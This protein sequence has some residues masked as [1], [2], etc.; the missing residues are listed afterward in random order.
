[1]SEGTVRGRLGRARERLRRR[2]TSRG[3]SVPAALIAAGVTS[4]AQAAIPAPLVHSTIRIALGF[5]AGNTAA[6]LAQGV[7]KSILWNQL[8]KVTVLVLLGIGGTY[9]LW[10]ALASSID[11]KGQAKSSQVAAKAGGEPAVAPARPVT[12]AASSSYRMTGMVRVE[13]TGEAVKGARLLVRQGEIGE[14]PPP[15]E[16]VV[17]TGADGRFAIDLQAGNVR[18]WFNAAPPGY[19]I[20]T[21]QAIFEAFAVGPNEPLIQKEYRVRKGTPW[22]VRFTRGADHRPFPGYMGG[23]GTGGIFYAQADDRGQA[24][25]TLPTEGGKVTLSILE[26][27]PV[28]N[29]VRTGSLSANLEWEP[30][31]RPDQLK[32]ITRLEGNDRRFRLIDI[33]AKSATLQAHSS[34]EPVK[35]DGKLIIRVDLADRSSKDLGS[36]TG[37]VLDAQGQPIE[38]AEVAVASMGNPNSNEPRHRATTD[39][40][41]RYRLL[42][43]PR[44]TIDGRP[45]P[46]RVLVSRSGYAGLATRISLNES[47]PEKPQIA[48]PIRLERGVAI[49][50]IV[51]DHR[52]QPVA[53]ASVQSNQPMVRPGIGGTNQSVQT[54]DNGRFI[55]RDLH[56]GILGLA[57]FHGKISK[58]FF[59]LAD[60]SPEDVRLQLPERQPQPGPDL[61]ALRAPAPKPLAVGQ[62][63]PD[64]QVGPWSDGRERE[65]SEERGKVVVLYFWGMLFW[66][67]VSALPPMEKLAFEFKPREVDFLAIHNAEPDPDH[68]QTQAR[69]VLAFKGASMVNAIDQIRILNHTRGL[70]AQQYGVNNYPVVIVIDRAGKIAFRSDTAEG[71]RNPVTVFRQIVAN[72]GTMTEEKAIEVIHKALA[73]EIERVLK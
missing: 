60:G 47:D 63:A 33:D 29:Q 24:T 70:T 18:A 14:N 43:L 41:G 25:L 64:W 38:G 15:K 58:S 32:D 17:E 5:M 4:Q 39:A 21:N 2:L 8:K 30:N 23:S 40:Q 34:I 35:E 16:R 57:V 71:D 49:G 10:Q 45:L 67:S 51:V 66:Q 62:A 54:D 68:F 6:L 19:W 69:K 73:Q 59:Y 37:Q 72:P 1:V 52:G 28:S 44:R 36:L 7:L 20:P 53:K 9:G 61:A 46:M 22:N 12:Q 27:S 55:L 11:D 13:G 48:D 56:R 65:L 3:V 31:F 26:S 42:D 50:G